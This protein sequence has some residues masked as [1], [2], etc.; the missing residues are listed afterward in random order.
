MKASARALENTIDQDPEFCREVWDA[1]DERHESYHTILHVAAVRGEILGDL[2]AARSLDREE[3]K[4]AELHDAKERRREKKEKGLAEDAAAHRAMFA[5]ALTKSLLPLIDPDKLDLATARLDNRIA[6]FRSQLGPDVG[7]QAPPPLRP[8]DLDRERAAHQIGR[9]RP[10]GARL[11]DL[12]NDVNAQRSRSSRTSG[13][14]RPPCT[15][16]ASWNCRSVAPGFRL[17]YSSR[18]PWIWSLPSV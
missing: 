17:R 4:A 6:G 7:R 10:P 16:K 11:G 13:I 14:G 5:M 1:E 8:A 3:L 12:G 2:D 9:G 15:T 18:N